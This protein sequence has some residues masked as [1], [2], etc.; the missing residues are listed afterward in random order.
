MKK[1]NDFNDFM[2]DMI[3]ESW[4]NRIMPLVIS[5]RLEE[6]L[7]K[8]NH[9]IAKKIL[10]DSKINERQLK[11][12][13]FID[14]DK[15]S[16]NK[17]TL[18]TA[19]TA[20]RYYYPQ[21]PAEFMNDAEKVTRQDFMKY[22]VKKDD[23][24]KAENVWKYGRS[25]SR[26]GRVINKLYP[27]EF[28][29]GGSP[30]EDIESFVQE[31]VAR[32]IIMRG[33]ERNRFKLISNKDISKYYDEKMYDIIDEKSGKPIIGS[34]LANSCM[35]FDYCQP[36][37]KYYDTCKGVR[38]LVLFSDVK[39]H[40]D[41]IVG[42]A[43]IWKLE[44]P[45]DRY[46]MDRIY[47]RYESDLALFKL[48]AKR[49]GWLHKKNQNS[50]AYV[51]IVDT[52]EN[53]T[54]VMYMRTPNTFK[55]SDNYPYMDTLKYFNI[56][57]GYLTNDEDIKNEGDS[58]YVLEDTVGGYEQGGE[59]LIYVDYYGTSFNENDIVRCELG[60]DWRTH[61]DAIWISSKEKYAT[62]EYLAN[63]M[64]WSDYNQEYL[65]KDSVVWS[66]KNNSY[67]NIND[68]IKI[69]E[70]EEAKSI[71]QVHLKKDDV[72]HKN[73][74]NIINYESED[75]DMY[76]FDWRDENPMFVVARFNDMNPRKD[77]FKQGYKHKIWDKDKLFKYNNIWYYESNNTMKD[78][79]TGQKRMWDN[80]TS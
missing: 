79:I 10:K 63:N 69:S 2:L 16:D 59:T 6:L 4:A 62:E 48:Y 58:V 23:N 70:N 55:K 47:Y 51:R 60:N 61:D 65:D 17:F 3:F 28:K 27:N 56:D 1:I 21:L 38:L 14:I 19:P 18:S 50:D 32:R 43:I 31:V 72:R 74:S 76:Y 73:N 12:V 78:K 39:G 64:I 44:K 22:D 15:T 13:T 71:N 66:N 77:G 52:K 24:F 25:Q 7:K 35:R 30:G 26:I 9:P 5:T 33:T 42:R 20:V 49:R 75:G 67:I 40:E 46:F 36:F 11:P 57:K 68:A 34:T 45:K 29:Q 37:V 41:K 54:K 8:I 53:I 80:E